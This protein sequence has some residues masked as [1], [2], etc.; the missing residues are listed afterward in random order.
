MNNADVIEPDAM[1]LETR[2][3]DTFGPREAARKLDMIRA[4]LAEP[5]LQ[6]AEWIAFDETAQ[7][8][9]L[10]RLPGG[11]SAPFPVDL[12]RVVEYYATRM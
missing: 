6:G 8:A 12:Q 11:D 9:R 1:P 4:T 2:L 5:P 10:T 3:G 7:M